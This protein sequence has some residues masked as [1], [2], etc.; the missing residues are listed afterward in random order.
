MFSEW[1]NTKIKITQIKEVTEIL[2]SFEA[3][4]TW[5]DKYLTANKKQADQNWLAGSKKK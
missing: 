2:Q 4:E 1:L 5:E 3:W